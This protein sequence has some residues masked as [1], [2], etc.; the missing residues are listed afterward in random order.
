MNSASRRALPPKNMLGINPAPVLLA[1]PERYSQVV[2]RWSERL[3]TRLAL[4]SDRGELTYAQ[5]WHNTLEAIEVLRD[6]EIRPGDRVLLV[7]E[8][9]LQMTPLLLAIS[10]LDAWAVP[11]DA[12]RSIRE[13]EEIRVFGGCRRALY[14]IGD[15]LAARNHAEADRTAHVERSF[16]GGV[17]I[18]ASN[19]AAQCEVVFSDKARQT[20]VLVFKS[21]AA[22]GPQGVMLSHQALMYM[23]ARA[24]EF[25]PIRP[26]DVVYYCQPDGQEIG[27]NQIML[28]AFWAG[29]CVELAPH[30][31]PPQ[32]VQA[33]REE[34][35]SCLIGE[36]ALYERLID[37]ADK[38]GISLWS[39]KLRVVETTGR[40]DPDLK[41]RIEDAF[42]LWTGNTY[43]MLEC[44][45]VAHST[46]MLF[47]DIGNS[48]PGIEIRVV[49]ENGDDVNCG[50][51]GELLVKG[52]C[53]MIGY[54]RNDA[55]SA[56]RIREGGWLATGDRA[57]MVEDGKV[58]LVE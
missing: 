12:R 38:R 53:L 20:A 19:E 6:L 36:S 22:G 4:R 34:R 29:A 31:T 15:S 56:A 13:I 16:L 48:Q 46:A 42:G 40:G 7:G 26:E 24:A 10:E 8:T 49:R 33:L 23:G 52:P 55:A 39:R 30:M 44:N 47:N 25:G 51:A 50:E 3:P 45:P 5:L 37:H 9:G 18:G 1:M 41:A 14:C 43:G 2:R 17:A 32:F 21:Q 27:L 54:Y 28:A 58:L 57:T 11:L 35:I